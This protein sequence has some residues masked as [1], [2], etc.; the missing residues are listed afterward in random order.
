MLNGQLSASMVVT[1]ANS[2]LMSAGTEGTKE[3]KKKLKKSIGK[4][5]QEVTFKIDPSDIKKEE[6]DTSEW[7]LLLKVRLC[8]STR[9]SPHCSVW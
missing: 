7:P 4:V 6:I 1:T 9:Y 2:S 8:C 3:H 5:H